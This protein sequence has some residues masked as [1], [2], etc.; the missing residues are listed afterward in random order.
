MEELQNIIFQVDVFL[1]ARIGILKKIW[2]LFFP[3]TDKR[4]ASWFSK[5]LT[6]S[7]YSQLPLL[8]TPL[9][10]R[11]SVLNSKLTNRMWFSVVCTL[12][13]NDIR[14]HSGQNVVHLVSARQILTT[15]MTN[16]VVDK[17]ADN[18]KP[19]SLCFLPQYQRQRK[20]LQ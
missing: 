9:G 5:G 14:H 8:R 1:C 18:T 11:V 19:H 16:I 6:K 15:V 13:D 10:P 17:S 2:P 7:L 20:F 12:I 3:T 4:S